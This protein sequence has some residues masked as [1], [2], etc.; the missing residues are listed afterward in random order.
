M[1]ARKFQII[2]SLARKKPYHKVRSWFVGELMMQNEKRKLPIALVVITILASLPRLIQPGLM[3]LSWD[4]LNLLFWALRLARYG[5]WIW[6]SNNW[7]GFIASWI[8]ITHHSPLNNYVVALA[9]AI[10]GH[11]LAP[12]VLMGIFGTLAVGLTFSYTKRYFGSTAA[13]VTGL[14][15]AFNLGSIELARHVLN[16]NLALPFLAGWAFTALVGYYDQRRWAQISHW[17]LLACAIQF[18]PANIMLAP[19]SL[20]LVVLAVWHHPNARRALVQQTLI[21]WGISGLTFIPWIIGSLQQSEALM[22]KVISE[23]QYG[24]NWANLNQIGWAVWGQF[25][26]LVGGIS[27]HHLQRTPLT[28]LSAG[29][30]DRPLWV[31]VTLGYLGC[32]VALF[33]GIRNRQKG[34]PLAF[35]SAL[36]V[37]IPLLTFALAGE[38]AQSYYQFAVLFGVFPVW[39]YLLGHGIQQGIFTRVLAIGVIAGYVSI[40]SIQYLETHLWYQQD[41][42]YQPL[43]APIPVF[44]NQLEEWASDGQVI[45]VVDT[46]DSK[47]YDADAQRYFWTVLGQGLP[48]RIVN[49][50]TEQGIPIPPDGATLVSLSGGA[51]LAQLPVQAIQTSG[52]TS[53]GHAPVFQSAHL[54][55]ADVPPLTLL[56]EGAT[57]FANGVTIV[58]AYWDTLPQQ[59]RDLARLNLLWHPAD[60]TKLNN[61]YHFSLRLMNGETTVGQRDLR[62]LDLALWRPEDTVLNPFE[63]TVSDAFDPSQPLSVLLLMYRY[64]DTGG[65]GAV[66]EQ[67]AEVAPWVI[68]K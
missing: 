47:Y 59:S 50:F 6:I 60:P 34:I 58:G 44:R 48:L 25:V 52:Q 67:G 5:E 42:W 14:L 19:F 13:W 61:Q 10:S 46:H 28:A 30:W 38:K 39:G 18:Q 64:E 26:E 21:G 43:M 17:V 56:P 23:E 1:L 29:M 2:T 65:I 41:G 16:P 68:L 27:F 36:G 22:E 4:E 24:F 37:F 35:L 49:R 32:V 11:P 54:S 33:I 20:V 53:E 15:F 12:R 45:M 51:T 40:S 8:P 57:R 62:S 9:Y 63:L 66:N 55:M 3:N 31:L 7:L